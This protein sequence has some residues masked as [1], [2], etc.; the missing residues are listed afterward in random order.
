MRFVRSARMDQR[1]PGTYRTPPP[2]VNAKRVPNLNPPESA[3]ERKS[4]T[5]PRPPAT[6]GTMWCQLFEPVR[7][8]PRPAVAESSGRLPVPRFRAGSGFAG[9]I[10]FRY[11]DILAIS[12][13]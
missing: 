7:L 2:Q 9:S 11:E 6:S 1:P 8:N 13:V 10:K 12:P 4:E 5:K 3:F